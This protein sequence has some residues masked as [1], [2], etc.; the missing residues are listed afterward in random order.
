[1]A[2]KNSAEHYDL[3]LQYQNARH[4]GGG[5]DQDSREQYRHFLLQSNVDT[6]LVEF[7]DSKGI[8]AVSIIDKLEDGLS[9]FT[10]SSTLKI[11]RPVMAHTA[12]VGR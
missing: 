4:S 12:F 9:S 2:L 11:D 1:M 3:Y 7:R 10:P 6:K 8:V 5:M